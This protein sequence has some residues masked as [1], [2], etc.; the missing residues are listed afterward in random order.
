MTWGYNELAGTLQS[1][2]HAQCIR[3]LNPDQSSK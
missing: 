1:N 3:E 2:Q